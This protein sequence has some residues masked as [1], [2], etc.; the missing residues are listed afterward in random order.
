MHSEGFQITMR[1][2]LNIMLSHLLL[3]CK[4]LKTQHTRKLI[5]NLEQLHLANIGFIETTNVF[6][7]LLNPVIFTEWVAKPALILSYVRNDFSEFVVIGHVVWHFWPV[8]YQ[9]KQINDFIFHISF[10][11]RGWETPDVFAVAQFLGKN[12]YLLIWNCFK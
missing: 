11:S 9:L 7:V 10:W 4:H 6:V 2:L 3:I 8:Y 12:C 1:M 5:L